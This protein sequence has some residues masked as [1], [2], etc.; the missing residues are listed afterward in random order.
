MI[1]LTVSIIGVTVVLSFIGFRNREFLSRMLFIPYL[2]AHSKQY[3]RFVSHAFM[4]DPKNLFHLFFNMF[5]LYQFG[6]NVELYFKSSSPVL[7]TIYYL[8]LYF[9]AVIFSSLRDYSKYKDDPN[10]IALGAS[11]AV[12][13]VLF[14]H[15]IIYPTTALYLFFIPIPIPSFI[16]GGLYLWFEHY[17]DKKGGD[18]IAHG[19]H[20]YGALFG[21]IFTIFTNFALIP[22]F[23][24]QIQDYILSFF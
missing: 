18:H 13:A 1:S 22:S 3:Y 8:I 4:H 7:G 15:I 19:A 24:A 16:F 2:I 21:V 14:S 9:G 6:L 11:G 12:S 20:L 17:M 5:V 23:F 10:Y